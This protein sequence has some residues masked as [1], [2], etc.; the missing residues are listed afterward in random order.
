MYIAC[1]ENDIVFVDN[2]GSAVMYGVFIAVTTVIIS[3][4]RHE[5]KSIN[6]GIVRPPLKM[7]YWAY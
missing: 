1:V 2:V 5:L 7:L 3:I 4:G 6:M